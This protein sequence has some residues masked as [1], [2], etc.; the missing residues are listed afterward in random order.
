MIQRGGDRYAY[1]PYMPLCVGV[2][3]WVL[4]AAHA[5]NGDP[6][7]EAADVVV[8]GKDVHASGA[9]ASTGLPLGRVKTHKTAAKPKES[10][11]TA[12]YASVALYARAL[13]VLVWAMVLGSLS[14][15]QLGLWRDDPT[16]LQA[17]ITKDPG[18][19]RMQD[20]HAEYLLRQGRGEEAKAVMERMLDS[21]PAYA[22]PAK[23][24]LSR[25]KTL[26]LLGELPPYTP[27]HTSP[28]RPQG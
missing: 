26:V 7:V 6:A 8:M 17:S 15:R 12:T 19:W 4:S 2:A 13:G 11:P 22:N 18:D 16:M 25:G 24:A 27:A 20:L 3:F 14:T 9:V 5:N 21:A 10:E 23:L 1:V 28:M